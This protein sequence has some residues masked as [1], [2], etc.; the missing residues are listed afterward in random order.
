MTGLPVSAR[1]FSYIE[2]LVAVG[3]LALCALPMAE[4]IRNG[5]QASAIGAAKALELRCVQNTM[6][7]VLAEPFENL[8]KKAGDNVSPSSY[9]RPAEHGCQVRNVF[10]AR[11][12]HYFGSAGKVLGRDDSTEDA[13]LLITVSSPGSTY[14]LVTLVDR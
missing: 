1:G 5:L 4:A 7:T 9:S 8:W 2:V 10:I 12:E 14:S 11:Y 6:E 13:M 3:L